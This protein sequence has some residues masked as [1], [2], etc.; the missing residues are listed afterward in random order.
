MRPFCYSIFMIYLAASLDGAL[1]N[2]I[3]VTFAYSN[4]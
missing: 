2:L 4:D 3:F 1:V